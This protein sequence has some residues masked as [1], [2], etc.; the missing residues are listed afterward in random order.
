MAKEPRGAAQ[1]EIILPDIYIVPRSESPYKI[2]SGAVVWGFTKAGV[3]Y[4]VERY[5][6][7]VVVGDDLD[8]VNKWINEPD[9]DKGPLIFFDFTSDPDLFWAL[10]INTA[11]RMVGHGAMAGTIVASAFPDLPLTFIV[12]ATATVT[13]AGDL[14][15]WKSLSEKPKTHARARLHEA[16]EWLAGREHRPLQHHVA[17]KAAVAAQRAAAAKKAAAEAKQAAAAM[18]AAAAAAAAKKAAAQKAAARQAVAKKAAEQ[19]AAEKAAADRKR[20]AAE[21]TA[22]EVLGPGATQRAIENYVPGDDAT[23]CALCCQPFSVFFL[24]KYHCRG[25]GACV[26]DGCSSEH[27]SALA[28]QPAWMFV[29]ATVAASTPTSVRSCYS[30]VAPAG[31]AIARTL[32]AETRQQLQQERAARMAQ[33]RELQEL[34]RQVLKT[35]EAQQERDLQAAK[36]ASLDGLRTFYHGTGVEACMSIQS[37]GALVMLMLELVLLLLL[38]TP[39]ILTGFRVDLSGTNAGTMLG[40]GVYLTTTLRKAMTYAETGNRPHGGAVLKLKVDLGRC[41]ELLSGD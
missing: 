20:A 3:I 19:A 6:Q 29:P 15:G 8:G 21:A 37:G 32:S 41:K 26:C 16:A 7:Y 39:L 22:R 11:I 36:K 17:K 30:C 40:D 31:D 5:A 35:T 13:A 9:Q 2:P 27:A 4:A 34:R 10:L 12:G 38:L 1:S 33:E 25:C 14:G 24:W 28:G 23:A 18:Q